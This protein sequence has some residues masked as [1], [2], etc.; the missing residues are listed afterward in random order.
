MGIASELA[1][2]EAAEKRPACV[3]C[4]HVAALRN[5]DPK[6]ADAVSAALRNGVVAEH[7]SEILKKNGYP[8]GASSIRRHRR[9]GHDQE[10]TT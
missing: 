1:A 6:D 7:L 9:L 2:L 8:V 5:D 3:V 10:P 4:S